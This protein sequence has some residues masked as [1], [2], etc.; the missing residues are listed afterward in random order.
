VLEFTGTRIVAFVDASYNIYHDSRSQSGIY[1]T[2]C[3][4]NSEEIING[5][6]ALAGSQVQRLIGRSSFDTE[7]IAL[8]KSKTPVLFLRDILSDLGVDQGPSLWMEDNHAAIVSV[9]QGDKFRGKSSHI[10]VRVHSFAQLIE[11]GVAEIR[12]CATEDMIA[13][14]LTKPLHTRQHLHSLLRLINDYG[15]ELGDPY[16]EASMAKSL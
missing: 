9:N 15:K 3:D 16:D 10:R 12:H 11:A 6:P 8:D 14:G 4:E 1:V 7:V 13:D 5:G 2:L